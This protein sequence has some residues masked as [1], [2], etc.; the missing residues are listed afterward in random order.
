MQ[1]RNK[2]TVLNSQWSSTK[3][4]CFESRYPARYWLE[5]LE[6]GNLLLEYFAVYNLKCAQFKRSRHLYTITY[7]ETRTAAVYNSK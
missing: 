3:H 7:R 2:N 6:D 5:D 1:Q 4:V